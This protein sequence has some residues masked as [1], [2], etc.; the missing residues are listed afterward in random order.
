MQRL[1]LDRFD[2]HRFDLGAARRFEQRARVG[3]IGLAA[4]HIGPDVARRQQMRFDPQPRQPARP[5]VCRPAGFHDH[6]IDPA[7]LEPPFE[8]QPGQPVLLDDFPLVIGD[9]NLEYTLGKIND[10]GS[11][12]HFGLLSSMTDPHPHEHRWRLF[13]AEKT[14]ESIPSVKPTVKSFAFAVGLLTR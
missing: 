13:G 14:G 11:S 7:V 5:V 1:L 6:Q 12:M 3:R 4:L 10:N 2:E 8:L 9:G